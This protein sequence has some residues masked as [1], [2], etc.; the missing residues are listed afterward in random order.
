MLDNTCE[1]NQTFIIGLKSKLS[2]SNLKITVL[3]MFSEYC[4]DTL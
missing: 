2:S 3:E 1:W 4:C